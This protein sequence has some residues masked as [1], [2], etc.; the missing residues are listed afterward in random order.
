MGHTAGI[1]IAGW[2]KAEQRK[3]AREEN[4]GRVRSVFAF[5]FGAAVLVYIYSDHS[6]LQNYIYGKVGPLLVSYE[7]HSSFKLTALK[8]ERDVN[9]INH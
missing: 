9:E 3:K 8:H 6:A 4:R 1:K 7:E 5:L 2:A